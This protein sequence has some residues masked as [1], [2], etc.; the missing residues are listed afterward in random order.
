MA[1]ATPLSSPAIHTV[2]THVTHIKFQEISRFSRFFKNCDVDQNFMILTVAKDDCE[3]KG[4][5]IMYL[6]V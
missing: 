5:L 2:T 6:G 4:F 3:I 1:P